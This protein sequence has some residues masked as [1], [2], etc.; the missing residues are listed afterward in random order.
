MTR[1]AT[2][3]TLAATAAVILVVLQ[4]ALLVPWGSAPD[5]L[6]PARPRPGLDPA[7]ADASDSFRRPGRTIAHATTNHDSLTRILP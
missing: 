2:V 1:S 3:R 5:D 4:G 6:D 7:P